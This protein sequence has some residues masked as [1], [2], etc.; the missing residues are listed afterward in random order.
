MNKEKLGFEHLEANVIEANKCCS[1]GGC[2]AACP[3]DAI[4]LQ[5]LRPTLVKDC[6]KCEFCWKSCPRMI[7]DY[8]PLYTQVFGEDTHRDPVLGVYRQ[9]YALRNV[10]ESIRKRAQ[11]GGVVTAILL[12]LLKTGGIEGAVISGIDPDNPWRPKPM[13]ATT[14]EAIVSATKSRYT[15]SPNLIALKEALKERKLSQIAVVGTP[16]H[17][18]AIQRMRLAPLK[19]ID[20]SVVMT[21]GLFCSETF[22]FKEL[23]EDKIANELGVPLANL[24]KLDI[25]G[26]LLIYPQGAKDAL[27]IP[28]SEAQEWID[29]GC[30]G[31]KDFA[32]DFADIS[33]GG[34]GT[35]RKWSSV[36]VRTERGQA[37]ID[38]MIEAGLFLHEALTNEGLNQLRKIAASKI[39]K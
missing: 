25:K 38:G 34:A 17:I 21:I 37:V 30:H 9:A 39:R 29:P 32:S 31:C 23:M 1:C 16:C 5:A 15:R 20:R 8:S 13:V 28:L 14:Q 19:K 35:P 3:I 4:E 33:V 7:H 22:K 36:L 11:D 10:D 2:E 27:Q 6:T 18:Q 26:K 12:H 24:R